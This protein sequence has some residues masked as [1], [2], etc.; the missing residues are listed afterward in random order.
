MKLWFAPYDLK[1]HRFI[2]ERANLPRIDVLLE[3]RSMLLHDL[4][5]Y[6][7]ESKAGLNDGFY[8]LLAAG[9][10]LEQLREEDGLSKEEFDRLMEIE[11]LVARLQSTFTKDSTSDDVLRSLWG[12][13]RKTKQGQALHLRWPEPIPEV[14]DLS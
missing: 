5:H 1:Q 9:F 12:A 14:V 3:T 7:Y 2:V 10:S 11:K 8:G 6:A 13:W 4:A